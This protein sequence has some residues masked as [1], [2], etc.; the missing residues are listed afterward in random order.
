[1][2]RALCLVEFEYTELGQPRSRGKDIQGCPDSGI[3]EVNMPRLVTDYERCGRLW[4]VVLPGL[5]NASQPGFSTSYRTG[6]SQLCAA[7]RSLTR[8]R[9][10]RKRRRGPCGGR[11]AA[12]AASC[13]Q[14]GFSL[15]LA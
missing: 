3:A 10:R 7:G 5:R 1:M 4:M 15:D 9:P 14:F 6:I 11:G 13:D 8:E 12:A 2:V